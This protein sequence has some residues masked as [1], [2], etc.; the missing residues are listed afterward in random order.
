MTRVHE[1]NSPD[2][3]K[4]I[5]DR[6]SAATS[7]RGPKPI[8]SDLLSGGLRMVL[9]PYC[10]RWRKLRG[11]LHQ[12]LS[13][14]MSAT[15]AASG[16]F[17][18]KQLMYDCLTDNNGPGGGDTF[19]QHVCR[20]TTSVMMTATYGRRV[21]K[22]ASP[23]NPHGVI[24]HFPLAPFASCRSFPALCPILTPWS[25]NVTTSARSTG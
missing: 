25:R 23:P 5:M 8:S 3:V 21:P 9:M 6:Q 15:F 10:E 22:W 18:A 13:P 19:Y 4:E 11:V 14:R 12:L 2:V 16:E 17:E 20:Y 24:L 7:S 1:Y